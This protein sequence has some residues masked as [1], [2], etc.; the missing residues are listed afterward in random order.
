[1]NENE[2]KPC[3]F[4]GGKAKLMDMG[5]PHWVYCENCGAKVH[6]RTFYEEDSVE[7]WNRRFPLEIR[8]YGE[9]G[10]RIGIIK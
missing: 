4:C 6:G 1:M 2:L 3:P 8:Q 5:F 10:M 9:N 7:A